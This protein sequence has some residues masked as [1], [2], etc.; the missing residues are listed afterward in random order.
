MSEILTD[1]RYLDI[2]QFIAR[3]GLSE[4]TIHRLKRAG[5]IPFFQPTGKGGKL[6]FPLDAI[7][8]AGTE[9]ETAPALSLANEAPKRLSGPSA[10]WRESK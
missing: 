10:K 1:R 3:T 7:E 2:T 4:A 9:I 8:R 6:L 5:K